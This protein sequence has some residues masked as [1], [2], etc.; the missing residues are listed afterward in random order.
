MNE[1][2]FFYM[3][4]P[5]P[6]TKPHDRRL[7][8]LER[9]TKFI[10]HEPESR[11]ELLEILQDAHERSLLDADS[12]S[13][14]EGVFRIGERRAGDIMVPRSQINAV[15]LAQPLS[16]IISNVLEKGHSRYPV[17]NDDV[18]KIVGILL[19]KDLLRFYHQAINN[20]NGYDIHSI[21]RPAVFIPESKPLNRLLH[22]FR[23]NRNHIA[24]VVSE[25]GHAAGLIT[26]EDVLEEIVGDIED[27]FDLDETE[28]NIHSINNGSYRVAALT[29]IEQFNEFFNTDFSDEDFD[30]IGGLVTQSFGRLAQKNEII[31]IKNIKFEISQADARQIHML[32]VYPNQK[33]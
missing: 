31:M 18:D 3:N 8:L 15:N 19:A 1:N 9:L 30:T 27:E 21:V 24:I 14:I 25:Y 10:S 26:I 4:D 29:K 6:H 5:D 12:L 20:P 33:I 7:T 13:M 2:Y 16:E 17:Y 28:N 11:A 22:D 23:D 32:T